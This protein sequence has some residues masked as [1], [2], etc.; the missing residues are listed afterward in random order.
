[1]NQ[2]HRPLTKG[3]WKG[4]LVTKFYDDYQ[5]WTKI[6]PFLAIFEDFAPIN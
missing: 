3:G 4:K 6:Y 5:K 1:M 2:Y